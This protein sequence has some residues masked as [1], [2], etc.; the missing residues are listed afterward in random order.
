M[1]ENAGGVRRSLAHDESAREKQ[2]P[3]TLR[4]EAQLNCVSLRPEFDCEV[5][6]GAV[7]GQD[8]RPL[9]GALD[10]S[11]SHH[12]RSMQLGKELIKDGRHVGLDFLRPSHRS[13]QTVVRGLCHNPRVRSG[14]SVVRAWEN[15]VALKKDQH[16][17]VDHGFL[18]ETALLARLLWTVRRGGIFW[19]RRNRF[20]GSYFDFTAISRCQF[21]RYASGTRSSSSP[22][23]KLMCTPASLPDGACGI[24][25]GSTRYW[26][27]PP[28]N[29]TT[30]PA[31]SLR[32]VNCGP[33]RQFH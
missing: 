30:F 9:R 14:R 13:I 17:S 12:R 2:T 11:P 5:T 24:A 7:K 31:N 25:C 20:L 26:R 18:P 21:S 8:E 28:R 15:G 10:S 33:Q 4:N 22:L 19:L 29:R 27:R 32:K 23:M 16:A 3:L 1:A 6:W